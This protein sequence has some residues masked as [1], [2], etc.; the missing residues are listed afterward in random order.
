MRKHQKKVF[1][2]RNEAFTDP[3]KAIEAI[4]DFTDVFQYKRLVRDIALYSSKKKRYKKEHAGNL[5]WK[6]EAISCML[7]ACF[8]I[9]KEKRFC[10]L[11]VL[12]DDIMNEKFYSRHEDKNRIWSDFPRLLSVEEFTNP[13]KAFKKIF[14]HMKPEQYYERF[15]ELIGYACG[16]YNDHFSGNSMNIYFQLTKL[17]EAAHLIYIREV[18]HVRNWRKQ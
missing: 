17:F 7:D 4:F 15:K 1:I 6:L 10:P 11:D 5:I 14:N 13:Y 9:N 8:T 12:D 18:A 2:W 16:S 3:Y